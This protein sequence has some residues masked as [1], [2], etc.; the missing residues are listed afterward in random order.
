VNLLKTLLSALLALCL[1]LFELA[2]LSLLFLGLSLLPLI[3]LDTLVFIFDLKAL[4]ILVNLV[5]FK[6]KVHANL[7][8]LLGLECRRDQVSDL[9]LLSSDEFKLLLSQTLL[10]ILLLLVI[11]LI[12]RI[13]LIL[14][15]GMMRLLLMSLFEAA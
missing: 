9:L 5:L 15:G 14:L 3:G 11:I 2:I 1:E 12:L 13:I 7:M 6:L 10:I 8:Q 4:K